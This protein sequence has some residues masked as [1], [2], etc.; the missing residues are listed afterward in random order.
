MQEPGQGGERSVL[1]WQQSMSKCERAGGWDWGLE[2]W[3]ECVLRRVRVQRSLLQLFFF[4]LYIQR[5]HFPFYLHILVAVHMKLLTRNRVDAEGQ[6]TQLQ[7]HVHSPLLLLLN[8]EVAL[9]AGGPHGVTRWP[10]NAH[11]PSVFSPHTCGH[12]IDYVEKR[13]PVAP[14]TAPTDPS[15]WSFLKFN[16]AEA[17]VLHKRKLLAVTY[18]QI[19][20]AVHNIWGNMS[21]ERSLEPPVVSEIVPH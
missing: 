3:G 8:P 5:G 7:L 6:T 15:R 16:A 2:D 1:S 9:L 4:F 12:S 20:Q 10:P 17:D 21:P 18:W 19:G 13:W 14:L 11:L